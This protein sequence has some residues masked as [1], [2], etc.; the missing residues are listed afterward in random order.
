MDIY[1]FTGPLMR[2]IR[3]HHIYTIINPFNEHLVFSQYYDNLSTSSLAS[4]SIADASLNVLDASELQIFSALIYLQR[5]HIRL[6]QVI[7]SKGDTYKV[8]DLGTTYVWQW[9]T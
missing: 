1:V 3:S 8:L 9:H 7:L 5:Q 2:C 4:R 6:S